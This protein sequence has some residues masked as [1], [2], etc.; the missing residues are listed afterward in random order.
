MTF[1]IYYLPKD[2]K[3]DHRGYTVFDIEY[4]LTYGKDKEKWFSEIHCLP[5]VEG[6]ARFMKD[7]LTEEN[8]DLDGFVAEAN[9]IQEIRAFLYEN[10]NNNPKD[11]IEADFFHYKIFGDKIKTIFESFCRK[12]GLE[13]N[14]D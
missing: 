14:I 4:Y 3:K 13:L 1:Q 7:K 12:Y 5:C 8:F 2:A 11:E 10:H 9:F 6:I